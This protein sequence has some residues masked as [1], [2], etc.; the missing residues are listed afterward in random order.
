MS[1]SPGPCAWGSS[2]AVGGHPEEPKDQ[3]RPRELR[4]G[5]Q[6]L[7]CGWDTAPRSWVASWRADGPA[8]PHLLLLSPPPFSCAAVCP[9][10]A[11]V[12]L[13][14]F[15]L[16]FPCTAPCQAAGPQ[17]LVHGWP[18]AG[19]S[20]AP[21]SCL[22]R[23]GSQ[24]GRSQMRRAAQCGQGRGVQWGAWSLLHA[25]GGPGTEAPNQVSCHRCY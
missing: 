21:L 13:P 14:G 3:S 6:P 20:C 9:G 15:S 8:G 24:Q 18:W 10:A 16:L 11:P 4:A 2:W 12:A 22:L 7:G 5:A 25:E 23:A 1:N 19:T 17:V